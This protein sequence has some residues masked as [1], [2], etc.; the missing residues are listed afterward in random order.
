MPGAC[1]RP[2]FHK[3]TAEHQPRLQGTV[4]VPRGPGCCFGYSSTWR[5]QMK[6]GAGFAVERA[7]LLFPAEQRARCSPEDHQESEVGLGQVPGIPSAPG[8]CIPAM[9]RPSQK[10]KN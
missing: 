3:V 1:P 6:S 10:T 5:F 9:L 8:S 7:C 4:C 2:L